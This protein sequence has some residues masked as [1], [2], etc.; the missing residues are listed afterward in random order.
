MNR[1]ET[2]KQ[3]SEML[4]K[5]LNP[6]RDPRKYIAREVTFGYGTSRHCRVDYMCFEPRN[7]SVSGIE[8]G[9]VF[10]YEIKSSPEDF[11]SS[12]GHN[13]IGD[14]NYYVM[15]REVYEK[16]RDSIS[17]TTGVLCPEKGALKAFKKA[18]R[19]NRDRPIPEILLMMFRS[20]NRE[21]INRQIKE[22]RENESP[23]HKSPEPG[24]S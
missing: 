14:Y 23:D 18:R 12:N 20:A 6:R 11:A 19:T 2:T 22:E 8:K 15:P 1:P 17:F 10:C 4:Y 3:L 16:V 24:W 7:N 9:D 13:L 21:I 5:Y